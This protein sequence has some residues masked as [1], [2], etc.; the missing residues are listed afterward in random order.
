[1]KHETNLK[2][3]PDVTRYVAVRTDGEQSEHGKESAARRRAL[4]SGYVEAVAYY[5][6]TA[7]AGALGVS[8]KRFRDA[9]E[10]R[11]MEPAS[12]Y[13][14][15]TGRC[16][17]RAPLWSPT[18][19]SSLAEWLRNPELHPIGKAP[20]RP[21]VTGI[22]AQTPKL[23]IEESGWRITTFQEHKGSLSCD[24][25]R[26]RV[27]RDGVHLADIECT[28]SRRWLVRPVRRTQTGQ[29]IWSLGGGPPRP[30]EFEVTALIG[31]PHELLAA[32]RS[33]LA[34]PL[35]CSTT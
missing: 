18:Q 6:T 25:D 4:K 7:A 12:T 9:T 29:I 20:P 22:P 30:D 1:M 21:V 2:V 15:F 34:I 5:S 32:V 14:Y 11:R 3:E 8:L 13:W 26:H 31:D 10:E 19:V 27:Y 24:V 33:R 16:G 35:V 23:L 28:R 17:R